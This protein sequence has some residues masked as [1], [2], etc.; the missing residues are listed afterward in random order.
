MVWH[1]VDDDE[2]DRL[3]LEAVDDGAEVGLGGELH[4]RRG[5]AH[6]VGAGADLLHRL[7]AGD[8]SAGHAPQRRAGGDLEQQGGFA[9]ARVAGQQY[10]RAGHHAAAADAVE[11]VHA[12]QNA[13]RGGV[14]ALQRLERQA[15]LLGGAGGGQRPGRPGGDLLDQGV[16]GLAARALAGP[17]CVG[18]PAG[19]ADIGSAVSGHAP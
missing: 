6:A 11:L 19:L 1:R 9:Y 7:L 2:I 8:V 4:G 18:R 17:F 5:E 16:P 14:L 13:G 10:G 12:R 3:A 15:A